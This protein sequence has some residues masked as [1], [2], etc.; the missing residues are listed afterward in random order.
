LDLG[1]GNGRLYELFKDKKVEYIGVDNCRKLIDLAKKK[2]PDVQ[3]IIG[4]ALRLPF[5]DNK[6]DLVF[7]IALLHHIP[8]QTYRLQVL[9]EI[10]RV[11]KPGGLLI[12]TVWNLYQPKLLLKYKI[13]PMIL[14]LRILPQ[15]IRQISWKNLDLRDV[16]IPWKLSNKEIIYRYYHA[17]TK[18]E[19]KRLIKQS[20]FKLLDCY[21]TH[22][23]QKTN[24]LK[25]V[26]LI[27]IVKK[28]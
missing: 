15:S 24:W 6:F 19:I 12:L 4:D 1:C 7:S 27:A 23:K 9:K 25:G 10:K 21:Y 13:W 16:F 5:E 3:F 11:L 2:Y 22:R 18:L 8:S 20:D 26:N 17:F 28:L 14:G